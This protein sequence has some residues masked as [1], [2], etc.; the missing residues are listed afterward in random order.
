VKQKKNASSI[1]SESKCAG[2]R[3]AAARRKMRKVV[4]F[5]KE[6]VQI[7]KVAGRREVS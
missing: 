4:E 2:D 6:S 7:F 1:L 3:P 5:R